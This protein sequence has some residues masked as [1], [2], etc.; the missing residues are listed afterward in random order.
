M[1]R[2]HQ[3]RHRYE[4]LC[5]ENKFI[6]IF[7][8]R[9]LDCLSI[10]MQSCCKTSFENHTIQFLKIC[11]YIPTCIIFDISYRQIGFFELLIMDRE[12]S[13]PG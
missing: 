1:R 6:I 4:I 5:R 3:L 11:T 8:V 10:T 12:R 13:A 9:Y 7:R 2:L